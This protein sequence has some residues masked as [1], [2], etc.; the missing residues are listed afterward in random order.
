MISVGTIVGD[1]V[2]VNVVCDNITVGLTVGVIVGVVGEG[3]KDMVEDDANSGDKVAIKVGDK[4]TFGVGD[5][6]LRVG[7]C[8]ITVGGLTNA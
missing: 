2:E 3:D 8:E 1:I 6:D 7:V 5:M 4:I